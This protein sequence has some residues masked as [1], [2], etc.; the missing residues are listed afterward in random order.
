MPGN[1]HEIHVRLRYLGRAFLPDY[2]FRQRDSIKGLCDFT[3]PSNASYEAS[4][5]QFLEMHKS[6]MSR[7]A[8]QFGSRAYTFGKIR[9][10][11]IIMIMMCVVSE[12]RLNY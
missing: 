3:C 11:S 6:G 8:Y 2:C 10:L 7:I 9:R 1:A 4:K 12:Y 5:Y